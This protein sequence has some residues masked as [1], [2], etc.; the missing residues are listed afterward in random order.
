LCEDNRQDIEE[1]THY[2]RNAVKNSDPK[3]SLAAIKGLLGMAMQ[4][5]Y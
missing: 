3:I 5:M 4:G 2:I 1:A